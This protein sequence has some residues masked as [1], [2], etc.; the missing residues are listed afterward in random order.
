MDLACIHVCYHHKTLLF[1]SFTQVKYREKY[2]NSLG[3]WRSMPD[4]PEFFH[5]RIIGE[6][7]SDVSDVPLTSENTLSS[8]SLYCQFQ[9]IW[10]LRMGSLPLNNGIVHFSVLECFYVTCVF[11]N[12]PHHS[13]LCPILDQVQGGSGLAEGYWL[14][15]VGQTWDGPGWEEQK[16]LQWGKNLG[17]KELTT[18]NSIR[19][20][21]DVIFL[22]SYPQKLFSPLL[23]PLLL[24]KQ[25]LYKATFEK[26][27][28]QFK[29]TSDTPFFQAAKNA[30][31]II[32]EVS[33]S[34]TFGTHLCKLMSVLIWIYWIYFILFKKPYENQ[35]Q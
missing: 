30:S 16:P 23:F 35:I 19:P 12:D 27:R 15:R 10:I 34:C 9:Y 1:L 32:N 3:T 24:W 22:F 5:S 17:K 8:E 28:H 18:T 25:R 14:L 20:F 2:I 26:N 4:R 31:I 29:Y 6:N 33:H 21:S 11:M 13:F 7:I